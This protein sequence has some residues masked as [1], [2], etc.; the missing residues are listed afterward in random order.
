MI[1]RELGLTG[2]KVVPIGFGGIP[3]QRLAQETVTAI[4]DQMIDEGINFID[5]CLSFFNVSL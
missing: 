4:I 5:I 3:I 1:T 2:L